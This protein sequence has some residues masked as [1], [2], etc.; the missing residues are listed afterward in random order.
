[1]KR[2]IKI[3]EVIPSLQI[4][5]AEKMVTALASHLNQDE[6]DTQVAVLFEK[7]DSRLEEQLS[8]SNIAI[9]FL[10][11]K[12]GPDLKIIKKIRNYFLEFS[13]DII[14]CHKAENLKYLLAARGSLKIPIVF[15]LHSDFSKNLGL[16][17]YFFQKVMV[18]FP[19]VYVVNL[20]SQLNKGLARK[21][22]SYVIP[23][24]IDLN[25]FLK[26]DKEPATEEIS[27]INIGRLVKAKNQQLLIGAFEE[28]VNINPNFKLSIIGDGPLRKKLS[29]III[30]KK[31]QKKIFI[32]GE[33]AD[34]KDSLKNANICIQCSNYEGMP[35]SI[36]EEM[37]SGRTVISS[38]VGS[39]RE[40]LDNEN[41]IF[42]KGNKQELVEK[43]LLLASN[44]NL[45][46]KIAMKL[47]ERSK[48]YSISKVA[49][50]YEKIFRLINKNN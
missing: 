15:T 12:N 26:I 47:R 33:L 22:Q 4:A 20:S 17:R 35:V 32:L 27:L 41:L 19:N 3:L 21:N 39:C 50:E 43:I 28:L 45:R 5:G 29:T 2:K 30:K 6:F 7:L 25:D 42:R 46:F 16:I 24:G 34:V 23:N 9:N 8:N 40:L 1:M 11:K 38:D 31:L 13:P 48:R 10:N 44:S 14:H 37:A 18:L 36:I 49:F